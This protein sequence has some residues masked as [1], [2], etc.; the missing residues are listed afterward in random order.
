ML[1]RVIFCMRTWF[2]K[3]FKKENIPLIFLLS[4][5]FIIR[6]IGI[7]FGLPLWIVPDE[8]AIVYA[9]L[10]MIELHSI[11]PAWHFDAF[12][13]KF[14]YMPFIAYVYIVPLLFTLG[15]KF[16]LFSGTMAEFKSVLQLDLTSFFITM[17]VINIFI[18]VATVYMVYKIS[19]NVFKSK[20]TALLSGAFLCLSLLHIIFSHWTRHWVVST[21]MVS[22]VLYVLTHPVWSKEK[23]YIL[24]ATFCGIGVG[25]ML[26]VSILTFLMI[27]W[28]FLYDKLSIIKEI[29]QKWTWISVVI[30]FSIFIIASLIWPEGPYLLRSSNS[31]TFTIQ[32]A[33]RSLRHGFI[34]YFFDILKRETTLLVFFFIGVFIGFKKNRK[35]IVPLFTGVLLYTFILYSVFNNLSRLILF[36]YPLLAVVAGYGLSEFLNILKQRKVVEYVVIVLVLSPLFINAILMDRLL[37]VND[38]RTQA[39]EWVN[40][41]IPAKSKILVFASALRLPTTAESIEE[42]ERIDASSLRNV[43]QAERKLDDK[44]FTTKRF[45][46]LNLHSVVS[47]T[48]YADLHDYIIREKYE[49]V[50]IDEAFAK[51]KGVDFSMS[52]FCTPIKEYEGETVSDRNDP[53]DGAD[54]NPKRL[55]TLPNI[56]P[57]IKLYKVNESNNACFK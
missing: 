3:I 31:H 16:L 47:S 37:L 10:K 8:P 27:I 19:L 38:T 13:G 2:A 17:R 18:G 32:N 15:M 56:G 53:I 39:Y 45:N 51:K 46:A 28:F 48:F 12:V 5:A 23:R 36:I 33:M 11:I 55:L 26:E 54:L 42:Q 57:S 44:F 24:S 52:E 49:Y 4:F 21:F 43:E 9:P 14:Y 50:V 20:K 30:F 22:L 7:N 40:K 29:K 6:L 35:F 41:N 1:F 34:F 25:M